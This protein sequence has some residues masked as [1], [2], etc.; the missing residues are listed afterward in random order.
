LGDDI[1][2][3]S[4]SVAEAYHLSMTQELKVEINLSKGLVSPIGGLEF[5]KR[6]YLQNVDL[7]PLPLKEFSS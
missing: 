5:A 6:F 7:T 4:A 3:A 2:I 1:V